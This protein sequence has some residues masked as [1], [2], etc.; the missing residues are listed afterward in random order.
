MHT[1]QGRILRYEKGTYLGPKDQALSNEQQ[2][3][4]RARSRLQK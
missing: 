1:K 4:L 2:A 3:D